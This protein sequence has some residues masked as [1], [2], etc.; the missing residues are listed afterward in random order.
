[1]RGVQILLIVAA[2]ARADAIGPY[3]LAKSL[4]EEDHRK[5]SER[6]SDRNGSPKTKGLDS[7]A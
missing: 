3:L 4:E 5:S 1:V 6:G 7:R 2:P